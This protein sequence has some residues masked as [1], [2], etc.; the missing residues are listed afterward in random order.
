MPA[1][2]TII[3]PFCYSFFMHTDF[4][5][6]ACASYLL[7]FSFLSTMHILSTHTHTYIATCIPNWAT[8][9]RYLAT[10][11]CFDTFFLQ[12]ISAHARLGMC[13]CVCVF[14]YVR[15]YLDFNCDLYCGTCM[16]RMWQ[17]ALVACHLAFK[18]LVCAHKSQFHVAGNN[19]AQRM[20]LACS[21]ALKVFTYIHYT[22]AHNKQTKVACSIC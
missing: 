2:A 5:V 3:S 1:A 7:P 17:V 16:Q 20:R 15:W 19:W 11:I 18:V 22:H 9:T 14:V 12:F 10:L 21:S 4:Y 13:V 8:R 6:T